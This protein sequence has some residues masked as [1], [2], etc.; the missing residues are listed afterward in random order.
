[1]RQ[2]TKLQGAHAPSAR[3]GGAAAHYVPV[4]ASTQNKKGGSRSPQV[5]LDGIVVARFDGNGR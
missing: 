3:M 2:T 1:M 4:L 5:Q